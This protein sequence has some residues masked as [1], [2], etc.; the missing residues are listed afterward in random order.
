[1][2]GRDTKSYSANISKV[3]PFQKLIEKQS[4]HLL[5]NLESLIN[6]YKDVKHAKKIYETIMYSG[7]LGESITETQVCLYQKQKIKTSSTLISDEKSIEQHSKRSDLYE[8]EYDYTYTRRTWL[9]YER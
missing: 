4:F 2:T 7:L 1:M 8:A 6:F 9:V 3:R 5:K